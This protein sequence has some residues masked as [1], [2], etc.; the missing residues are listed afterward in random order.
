MYVIT[1]NYLSTLLIWFN[2]LSN[3]I[4]Q[5]DTSISAYLSTSQRKE[6]W[7]R[8]NI[9][10]PR[11]I[12]SKTTSSKNNILSKGQS[13]DLNSRPHFNHQATSASGTDMLVQTET[14]SRKLCVKLVTLLLVS[15]TEQYFIMY[16]SA[17]F[18]KI[19]FY[20]PASLMYLMNT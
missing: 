13:R 11:F 6:L 1:S 9:T 19:F 7:V 4:R 10:C 8:G 12:L 5:I 3:H 17:L 16:L 14:M 18:G 20:W 15:E 2:S